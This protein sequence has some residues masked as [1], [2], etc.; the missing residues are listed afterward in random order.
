[1]NNRPAFDY[2]LF[3]K[4]NHDWTNSIFNGVLPYVRESIVWVPLYVFLAAFGLLNY[5]KRAYGWILAAIV[6]AALANFISSD[7]IK[8]YF[9]SDRPCRDASLIP[10]ANLLINRCPISSSFTSSHAVNHFAVAMF[11][12]QTMRFSVKKAWLFFLW[13]FIIIYAQVYVGVH[14][15]LDVVFGGLLGCS[16]GYLTSTLYHYRAGILEYKTMAAV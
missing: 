16:I 6:T 8:T 13:A 11:L 15:P 5:G 4:I 2:D 3:N 14:Y 1:L 12:F 7:I 10:E 9:Y